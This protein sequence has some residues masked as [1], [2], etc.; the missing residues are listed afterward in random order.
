MACGTPVIAFNRGSVPEIVIDGKTGFIIRDNKLEKMADAVKKI[1]K[2]NLADC[3]KHVE[4]NFSIQRMIDR[5][6]KVF[7]EK[8]G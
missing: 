3:R 1:D 6:E 5:Y 2:I 7:Y 4:Q 8:T